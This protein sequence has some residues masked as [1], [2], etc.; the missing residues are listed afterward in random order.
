V[1]YGSRINAYR[2]RLARVSKA[3]GGE[4]FTLLMGNLPMRNIFLDTLSSLQHALVECH[5]KPS[6]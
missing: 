3:A 5:C 6:Y 1:D 4:Q 2:Y